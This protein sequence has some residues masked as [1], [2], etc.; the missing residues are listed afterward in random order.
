MSPLDLERFTFVL[1]SRPPGAPDLPEE[2]LN[3]IQQQHL[4]HLG[5]LEERGVLLLAG[6]FDDQPDEALRGLCVFDLGLEETRALMA[7]DPA[8]RAGRLAVDVMSWWTV[9]DRVPRLRT[10]AS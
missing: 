10:A 5:S 4:A 6:P 8:V 3:E 1:L 2:R 9:K 7:Q